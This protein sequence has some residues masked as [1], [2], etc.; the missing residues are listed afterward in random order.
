MRSVCRNGRCEVVSVLDVF[1]KKSKC[2]SKTPPVD[3]HY[4]KAA[5]E[6]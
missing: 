1:M 4:G 2:G 3:D 5:E 6:T